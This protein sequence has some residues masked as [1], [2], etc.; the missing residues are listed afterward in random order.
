M[1][2][3]ELDVLL[4]IVVGVVPVINLFSCGILVETVRVAPPVSRE[5][6][7]SHSV[8]GNSRALVAEEI[9]QA[10]GVVAA[11]PAEDCEKRV[12]VNPAIADISFR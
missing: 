5:L 2:P 8:P 6:R 4:A 1:G 12:G 9:C 11:Y 7:E 10:E 3:V